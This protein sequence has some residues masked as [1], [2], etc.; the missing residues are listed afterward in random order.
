MNPECKP[1]VFI[2]GMP[3]SGT[4]SLY[5]YLKQHPDIYLSV[6][7]EPH[8]FG[9]DLTQNAYSI[10]DEAVYYSLFD[11]AAGY[12]AV[13]EGSVW[14]LTSRTAA[15]EIR[16]F[17]PSAKIIIMLRNPVDMIYSLHSLYVRTGNEDSTDF[18]EALDRQQARENGESLPSGCYFPEGLFYTRV[19]AYYEK[20]KRFTDTFGMEGVHFV[21]FDDFAADTARSYREVLD[22]LGVDTGF[23]A[24]FDLKE[25]DVSIR[26]RVF[27][28]I[29]HA[30]PEVR[31]KLAS[32]TGLRA[33]K[34]PRREKLSPELIARLRSLFKEDIEKTGRLIGR[35]LTHW[36]PTG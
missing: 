22:F 5:T 1:N 2:A 18:G 8:F 27:N 33:H 13:G 36:T 31:K 32:K 26:K 21:I 12:S 6:Y 25:A 9:K 14:Y 35:N 19:A 28:E 23:R 11:R 20:I 17:N 4:T 30:H 7:K 24:V 15:S 3:R 10:Q 29:R 16:A 34:G